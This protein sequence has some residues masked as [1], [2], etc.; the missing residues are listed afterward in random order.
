VRSVGRWRAS[1]GETLEWRS[2]EQCCD[3]SH[4]DRTRATARKLRSAEGQQLQL[5][6]PILDRLSQ[7]VRQRSQAFL[8]TTVVETQGAKPAEDCLHRVKARRLV[9]GHATRCAAKLARDLFMAMCAQPAA[10]ARSGDEHALGFRVETGG[11]DLA[12]LRWL[13]SRKGGSAAAQ[14]SDAPDEALGV[15]SE[16]DEDSRHDQKTGDQPRQHLEHCA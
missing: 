8:R 9:A 1:D 11:N 14:D 3:R 2:A 10:E 13:E 7:L 5:L 12:R 15:G 16:H 4:I 6:K